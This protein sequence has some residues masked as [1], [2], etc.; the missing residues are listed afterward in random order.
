MLNSKLNDKIPNE[1]NNPSYPSTIDILFL[2]DATTSMLPFIIASKEETLKIS[3]DLHNLYPNFDFQYGYIFYRDPIDS[4]D[5]FHELIN[6]TDQLNEIPEKISKI[7]AFGGGDNPEDWAGAY[8]LANDE[9]KW[10]NGEKVIF[11]FADDGAHGTKFYSEDKYPEEDEKLLFELQ[12]SCNNNIKI[13]GVVIEE[14]AR[15]SFDECKKFYQSIG[16]YFEVCNF[17]EQNNNNNKLFEGYDN[18]RKNNNSGSLF[19]NN[20]NS[21]NLFGNKNN[22]GN[23]FVNNNN[24][25]SLFGGNTN[26]SGNLF[27]NNNNSGRFLGNN[28]TNTGSLFGNNSTNSG[29]LFGNNST[30]SGSLFGNNSTNSGSIFGNKTNNSGSIFSSTNKS[31]GLNI[32]SNNCIYEKNSNSFANN[33]SDSENIFGNKNN[34]PTGLFNNNNNNSVGLF[35]NKN[36]NNSDNLIR[37]NN[38]NSVGLFGN[39]IFSNNINQSRLNSQFRDIVVNSFKNIQNNK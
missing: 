39:S 30:N 2:I 29:S 15:N 14:M 23:L 17:N 26:N 10:R 33:N 36:N 38:N 3:E 24:S 7:R 21:G 28:S 35:G 1:N 31:K 25:G 9:I 16:G 20:N 32:F 34:V 13:L 18:M 19:G 4:K 37:N 5:D 6:L 12:K 8:K 22:S 27:G 11:H